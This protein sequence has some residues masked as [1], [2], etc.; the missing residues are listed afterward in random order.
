MEEED[1][2]TMDD[3]EIAMMIMEL[4]NDIL[5]M[6]AVPEPVNDIRVFFSDAFY[7]SYFDA[8]FPD[9]DFSG[10]QPG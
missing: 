2:D 8:A 3:E 6:L 9:I 1:E 7:L 5:G 10:L 4:G